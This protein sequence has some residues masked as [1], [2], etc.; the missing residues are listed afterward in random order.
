MVVHEWGPTHGGDMETELYEIELGY[1][2]TFALYHLDAY[3][4]KFILG[5]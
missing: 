4:L 1:D 3:W 2:V 5:I